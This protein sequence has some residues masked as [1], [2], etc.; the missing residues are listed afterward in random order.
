MINRTA[1]R[2][3]GIIAAVFLTLSVVGTILIG[4][5]W[6]MAN[7]DATFMQEFRQQMMNEGVLSGEEMDM[8][9]S[10]MGSFSMIIWFFAAVA[11]IGLI[12]NIIGLTKVWNNKNPKAAGVLFI[13][14]GLFG[15]FLSLPSIL[16]YVAGIL[17]FTKTAPMAPG[18]LEKEH[19]STESNWMN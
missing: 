13:I 10:F 15:G 6:N 16:L 17:C 3:L 5:F 4:V 2:V 7:Q 9:I 1:E 18:P 11:F 19:V 12:L 14:A 8:F